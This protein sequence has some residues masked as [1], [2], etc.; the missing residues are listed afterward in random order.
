MTSHFK[1][2]PGPKLEE[3]GQRE[4]VN[5]RYGMYLTSHTVHIETYCSTRKPLQNGAHRFQIE[6]A[7]A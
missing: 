4:H 2:F 6:R 5:K 7:P 1:R 3:R